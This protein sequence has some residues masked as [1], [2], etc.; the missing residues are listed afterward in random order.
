VAV[1]EDEMEVVEVWAIAILTGNLRVKGNRK[2]AK[3]K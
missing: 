1:N 2:K 3:C